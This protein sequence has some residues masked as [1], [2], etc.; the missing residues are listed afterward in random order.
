MQ[1]EAGVLHI[2]ESASMS[3]AL[4]QQWYLVC[5]WRLQL[6]ANITVWWSCV[7]H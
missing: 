3:C 7:Q 2:H 1:Q 6:D 5:L 4:C